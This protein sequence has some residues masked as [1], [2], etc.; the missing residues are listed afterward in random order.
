MKILGLIPAME[1]STA[2]W[3]LLAATEVRTIPAD[4]MTAPVS[5]K[6]RGYGH[7]W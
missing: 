4:N 5:D 2:T 1:K 7:R 6:M 3:R